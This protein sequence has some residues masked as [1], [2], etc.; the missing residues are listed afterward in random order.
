VTLPSLAFRNALLRNKTRALL[1]LLAVAV[2]VLAFVFVR[3]V[4]SAFFEGPANAHPDRLAVR[5][6]ISLVVPLPLAD[7]DKIKAVPGVSKVTYSNWFGGVYIEPRNF[8]ARFAV[9]PASYFDVY[10]DVHIDPTDLAAFKADRTGCLIGEKLAP[11]YGFKKGDIIKLKGDI[12]PGDWAYKVDGI[13]ASTDPFINQS[14]L[15]QWKYLDSSLDTNR[16][17][18]VG[19]YSVTVADASQGP[20]VAKAID[21]LF[22]SSAYETRTESEKTFILG[23]INGSSAIIGALE[24]V[25]FVLLVIMLLILGNT[26]SMAL[27]ERTNELAVL[28][29][30]GY[31]PGQLLS[32][33]LQEGIW[34]SIIGGVLG[35]L[36]SPPIVKGFAINTQ[37]FI[38][39]ELVW[40]WVGPALG[41]A[42][43]MGILASVWP[44]YRASKID[45]VQALRRIE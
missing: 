2:L 10:D 45:I 11:K 31:R 3:T 15:F 7:F 30:L 32:L 41:I 39:G 26:L 34:L 4:V 8:F 36:V 37:G 23:F 16:Q 40:R 28:R 22:A 42:L 17:G 13:F 6:R 14:M 18:Y 35:A 44:A 43:G 38:N 29:T 5:N 20:E 21:T 33:A 12:Y 24:T 9:D 27:R 25:S 19:T 1:T